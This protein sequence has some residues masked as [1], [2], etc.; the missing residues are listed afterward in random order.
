MKSPKLIS[1]LYFRM[2]HRKKTYEQLQIGKIKFEVV[3]IYINNTCV[4][5]LFKLKYTQSLNT[6]TD[7]QVKRYS[8]M[9]VLLFVL[10]LFCMYML[11]YSTLINLGILVETNEVFTSVITPYIFSDLP[12]YYTPHLTRLLNYVNLLTP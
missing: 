9:K 7:V 10:L 12:V 1:K 3:P 2:Q 11:L 6:N 4:H 8:L 5:S